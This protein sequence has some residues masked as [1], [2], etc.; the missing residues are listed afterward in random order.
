MPN[1]LNFYIHGIEAKS[2]VVQLKNDLAISTGSACTTAIVEPSHVIL[3]LGYGEQRAYSSIRIGIGR[4]T[5]EEEIEYCAEKI[6][7]ATKKLKRLIV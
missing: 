6:I 7:Q 3:A 1:N 4:Y 2:L 5:T